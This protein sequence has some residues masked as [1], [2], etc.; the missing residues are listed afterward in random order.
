MLAGCCHTRSRTNG[1][2][3]KYISFGLWRRQ[4]P[5]LLLLVI[6][7]NKLASLSA[8]T[9]FQPGS[10]LQKKILFLSYT[11]FILDSSLQTFEEVKWVLQNTLAVSFAILPSLL[12]LLF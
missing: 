2:E 9:V 7:A 8:V 3:L 10:F 11:Y 5:L 6:P 12:L 1:E 4:S